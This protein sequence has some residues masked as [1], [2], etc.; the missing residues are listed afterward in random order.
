MK[1]PTQE[2]TYHFVLLNKQLRAVGFNRLQVKRF[3]ESPDTLIG[4]RIVQKYANSLDARMVPLPR[5]LA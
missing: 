5:F 1:R 3:F 4:V 2:E